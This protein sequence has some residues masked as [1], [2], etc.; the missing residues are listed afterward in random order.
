MTTEKIYKVYQLVKRFT[1]YTYFMK[2]NGRLTTIEFKG[3]TSSPIFYGGM[4]ST[5]DSD[6]QQALESHQD[7][8]DLFVCTYSSEVKKEPA[9]VLQQQIEGSK[10]VETEKIVVPG[11]KNSVDAKKYLNATLGVPHSKMP[12]SKVVMDIAIEN[13]IVFPDWVINPS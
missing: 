6:I 8:N 2:V 7:F 5:E 10:P 12:N 1:T 13:N 9:A 11:I 3:G 4:F